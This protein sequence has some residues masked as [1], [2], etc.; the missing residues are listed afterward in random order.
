MKYLKNYESATSISIELLNYLKDNYPVGESK[1]WNDL[2]K[3]WISVDDKTVFIQGN[4]S[5]LVNKICLEVVQEFP[6]LDI[7]VI[8]RTIKKFLDDL[9]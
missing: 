6:S 8:R 7:S 5:Y 2:T 1:L 3:K 9:I 4:K